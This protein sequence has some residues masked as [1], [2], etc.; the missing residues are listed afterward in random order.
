VWLRNG[1]SVGDGPSYVVS[2]GDVGQELA[3]E[4][5]ATNRKGEA[6]S[7]TSGSV[8]AI[9]RVVHA[10]PEASTEAAASSA[11]FVPGGQITNE[12][13]ANPN[14]TIETT[15]K[16]KGSKAGFSTR[17]L[18]VALGH[19]GAAAGRPKTRRAP[20][21]HY[22]AQIIEYQ[23]TVTN[24][25]NV[26]LTLTNLGDPNCGHISPAGPLGE[27]LQPGHSARYSCQRSVAH[28][29]TYLNQAT[30]EATPPVGDGFTISRTSN[31]TVALGPNP[32]PTAE[33]G[34]ATE[35]TQR[36]AL[37]AGNVNPHGRKVTICEFEYWTTAAPH[38]ATCAKSPGHG[39][40][41]VKVTA[42]LE[43]LRPATTYHYAIAAGNPTGT[44]RG[45]PQQFTTPAAPEA[46]TQTATGVG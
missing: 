32:E 1:A 24:T 4:V 12:L 39:T 15:Q 6:A 13:L 31:E 29:G 33:T 18:T 3:C 21:G 28:D 11:A 26:P 27:Q 5:T 7:A 30:I 44:S 45:N 43:N 2:S 42:R 16:L 20:R 14:L 25:G 36:S 38:R 46:I 37:V 40:R 19:P 41:P 10:V 22:K 17:E 8:T 23:I 9:A 34:A 35:V